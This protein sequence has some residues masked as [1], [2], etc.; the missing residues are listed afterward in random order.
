MR[1]NNKDGD[2][3]GDEDCNRIRGEDCD[4]VVDENGEACYTNDEDEDGMG[5]KMNI[6]MIVI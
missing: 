6:V 1:R 5:M 4:E 2:E 3:D